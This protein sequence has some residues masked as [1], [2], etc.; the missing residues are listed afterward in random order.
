MPTDM[1]I[2]QLSLAPEVQGLDFGCLTQDDLAN[3]VLQRS[4]VLFD[5]PIAGKAIRRW[6]HGDLAPMNEAIEQVGGDVVAQRAAGVILDDYK[7][8]APVLRQLAPKRVA[9]IG[10]G[11]AFFDLFLGQEFASDIVLIDLESNEHRHFGF[12]EEGAAYSSLARA[13][14]LL[15][16]NGIAAKRV[17][18][19]NPSVTAPESIT[20]VD[21]V[22]S[23]LSC[24]FHYP[25]G[26]YI[27][28]LEKALVPGGA[29]IFDLR[30][31][32]A[33][34][35]M[36]DLAR[37]GPLTDLPVAHEKVRRVMLTKAAA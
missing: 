20:P 19:L 6:A 17:T 3:L 18:T 12:K 5:V 16:A 33:K 30:D 9:D 15:C 21:L 8:L 25:I 29:A 36:E 31:S 37:L 11:Y 7:L 26:L 4:E 2:S 28:F 35:Q 10:C 24:G 14:E 27:P 32:T 34:G 23:F 13:K 1:D 22:V